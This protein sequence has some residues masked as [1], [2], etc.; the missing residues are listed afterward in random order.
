MYDHKKEKTGLIYFRERGARS[1]I[2]RKEEQAQRTGR[3]TYDYKEGRAGRAGRR[4]IAMRRK[5][6]NLKKGFTP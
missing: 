3:S 4:I 1:M 5:R 2:T 6:K